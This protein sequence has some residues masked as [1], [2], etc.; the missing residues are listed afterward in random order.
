MYCQ[1]HER[2]RHTGV[3]PVD[4][5]Q[6]CQKLEPDFAQPKKEKA[7]VYGCDLKT[8]THIPGLMGNIQPIDFIYYWHI[9]YENAKF[10]L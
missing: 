10:S 3:N 4:V 7:Q 5:Y 9:R 8:L 1:V 6:Y 2:H